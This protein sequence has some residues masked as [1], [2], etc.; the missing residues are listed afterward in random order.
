MGSTN[1]IQ[2]LHE[3][4]KSMKE[5]ND[6]FCKANNQSDKVLKKNSLRSRIDLSIS[7]KHLLFLSLQKH[8]SKQ[9]G[10]MDHI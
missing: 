6:C 2:K 9:W 4:R 7:S 3:S 10:T 5:G 1:Q 8:H